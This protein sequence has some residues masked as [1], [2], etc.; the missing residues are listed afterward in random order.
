LNNLNLI[1]VSGTPEKIDR[2][3]KRPSGP[4][5][6]G[7]LW[8]HQRNILIALAAANGA[9]HRFLAG[10]YDL[11]PAR[12]ARILKE[13]RTKYGTHQQQSPSRPAGPAPGR[14]RRRRKVG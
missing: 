2:P 4:L 6:P 12:I 5:T 10:Q 1:P 8:R 14:D 3:R 11:D 9:S 13:Y 7:Q